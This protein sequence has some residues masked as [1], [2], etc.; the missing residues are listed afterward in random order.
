VK[1][2]IA[3]VTDSVLLVYPHGGAF[4]SETQVVGAL[5][6]GYVILTWPRQI[7]D[8]WGKAT[9][10]KTDSTLCSLPRNSGLERSD[11]RIQRIFSICKNFNVNYTFFNDDLAMM[12]ANWRP[13]FFSVTVVMGNQLPLPAVRLF[14]IQ[15][16]QATAPSASNR[17]ELL[18]AVPRFLA[19]IKKDLWIYYQMRWAQKHK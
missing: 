15:I 5:F 8:L 10:I 12:T 9:P 7:T 2:Q 1:K 16:Y 18:V 11:I 3:R 14:Y 6:L 13:Y 4:S 19:A 17:I